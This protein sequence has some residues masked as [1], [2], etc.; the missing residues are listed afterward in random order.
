MIHRLLEG[1]TAV[2]I[3]LCLASIADAQFKGGTNYFGIHSGLIGGGMPFFGGAIPL[4]IDY[5][6]GVGRTGLL[7][8]GAMF[9][10]YSSAARYRYLN[11]AVT[12]LYHAKPDNTS[13]DP[14]FGVV[15]VY[16]A[17]VYAYNNGPVLTAGLSG[18]LRYFFND[19]LAVQ[20]KLGG[21]P[22]FYLLSLGIGYGI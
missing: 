12:I 5:E 6:I 7:G 13:W 2:L 22:G 4:G 21:G 8:F 18:G 14:S 10:Y 20:A 17:P 15:M 3:V 1:L 19:D 11:L 16:E 9:D